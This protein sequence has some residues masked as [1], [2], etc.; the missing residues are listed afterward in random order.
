LDYLR[1][2]FDGE[3]GA[4][5]R[6]P[7][8]HLRTHALAQATQPLHRGPPY[9]IPSAFQHFPTGCAQDNQYRRPGFWRAGD[10]AGT[11]LRRAVRTGRGDGGQD[12]TSRWLLVSRR[13]FKA[14]SHGGWR[15]RRARSAA[16]R[17]GPSTRRP[18]HREC[19]PGNRTDRV[20]GA[21][22]GACG[23][24][25]VVDRKAKRGHAHGEVST[26]PQLYVAAG[27]ADGGDGASTPAP[28]AKRRALDNGRAPAGEEAGTADRRER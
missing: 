13:A 16:M 18:R 15:R 7:T 6:Q 10:G 2:A 12:P 22:S 11:L 20:P 28:E 25:Q 19:R 1:S 27:A 5:E 9:P 17:T 24:T 4:W 21:P 3:R 14:Q 26:P 23:Y 8:K